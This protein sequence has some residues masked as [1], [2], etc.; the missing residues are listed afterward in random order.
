MTLPTPKRNDKGSLPD[1]FAAARRKL[2]PPLRDKALAQAAEALAQNRIKMAGSLVS[3]FL[4]N[5]ADDPDA[6]DLMATVERRA[7]R[8]DEAL[9]LMSRCIALSPENA[10]YRFN[11]VGILRGLGKL[12]E[13][14]TQIDLLLR[15]DPRNPLYRDLKAAVLR[16]LGRHDEAVTYRREMVEEYPESAEIWLQYGRALRV[17]DVGDGCVEAF[18]K[19]LEV[20]PSFVPAYTNLASLKTYR[21]TAAEVEQME[22]QL[23]S[24]ALPAS[25]RADLHSAL[26]KAYGDEKQYARSFENFAKGNALRRL[27]LDF[28]PSRFDAHR[29][30]C[31]SLFTE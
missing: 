1:P 29:V 25:A 3:R 9:Q 18:R 2:F 28:D 16:T 26:G 30:N 24:P 11:Y 23:A 8:L 10:G 6:L 12:D 14:L 27:G 4:R 31:E 13:A 17:T 21:F 19:A 22:R 7:G 5:K 15:N 20:D